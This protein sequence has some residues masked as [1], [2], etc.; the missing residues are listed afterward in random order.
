[1]FYTED[2]LPNSVAYFPVANGMSG[3]VPV[4]VAL[5]TLDE[6]F[7]FQQGLTANLTLLLTIVTLITVLIGALVARRFITSPISRLK[8]VAEGIRHGDYAQR[9][10]VK[11]EDEIGQLAATFNQMTDVLQETIEA[12]QQFRRDA[13]A[14]NE[15]MEVQ[16]W[17][18]TGQI[19]AQ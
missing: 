18:T 13:E 14:A 3:D 10:E 6:L 8:L 2:G 15:A 9:A 7:V 5:V 12:E 4:I 17:Q 1:M 11:S 16:I 19:A